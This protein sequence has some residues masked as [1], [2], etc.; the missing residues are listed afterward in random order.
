[1]Y[2]FSIVFIND[3]FIYGK[4]DRF[5]KRPIRFILLE[6]EQR[7]FLKMIV[8][9]KILYDCFLKNNRLLSTVRIAKLQGSSSILIKRRR[10]S[11]SI[12]YYY[13]SFKQKW[14]THKYRN[15][16]KL[17]MNSLSWFTCKLVIWKMLNHFII[18]IK[19]SFISRIFSTLKLH[20][21][22]K[23]FS[24]NLSLSITPPPC[25]CFVIK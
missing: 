14:V 2:L 10:L 13:Q 7:S 3:S 11:I 18:N 1:M 25:F 16:E 23:L 15:K 4:N 5:W 8:F 20:Y 24:R 6:N 21:Y 19:Y 12:L 17:P 22:S 9:I